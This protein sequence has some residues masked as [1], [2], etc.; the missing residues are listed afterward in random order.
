M[1]E[2]SITE[3]EYLEKVKV[4]FETKSSDGKTLKPKVG[5]M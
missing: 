2:F 1:L 4:I 5:R 3:R